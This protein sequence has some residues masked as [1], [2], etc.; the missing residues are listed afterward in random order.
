MS[1][2]DGLVRLATKLEFAATG[3]LKGRKPLTQRGSFHTAPTRSLNTGRHKQEAVDV[4]RLLHLAIKW[5][6]AREDASN[7]GTSSL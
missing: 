3:S 7:A 1:A 5:D 6:A 2:A 4:D